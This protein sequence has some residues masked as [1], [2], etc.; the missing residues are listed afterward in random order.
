MTERPPAPIRTLT[1]RNPALADANAVYVENFH[2]KYGRLARRD[3]PFNY[4]VLVNN[5]TT[6]SL[7]IELNQDPA[8][9]IPLQPGQAFADN[10]EPFSSLRVRTDGALSAN[11]LTIQ[12]RRIAQPGSTALG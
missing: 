9:L 8:S 7:E 12:P 1:Y 5:S 10:V 4:V 6:A 11:E 2:D 3:G